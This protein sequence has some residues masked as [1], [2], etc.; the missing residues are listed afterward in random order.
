LYGETVKRKGKLRKKIN[1][2]HQVKRQMEKKNP[3]GTPG[4]V[5]FQKVL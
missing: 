2:K 4:R 3:S 5:G 1:T